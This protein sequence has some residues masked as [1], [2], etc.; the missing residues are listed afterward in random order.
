MHFLLGWS[1]QI[2]RPIIVFI[3]IA[4]VI[5]ALALA[6][7]L[8]PMNQ[9]QFTIPWAMELCA[10]L[11]W[12]AFLPSFSQPQKI[13]LGALSDQQMARH[14]PGLFALLRQKLHSLPG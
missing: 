5:F 4:M 1:H 13:P 3:S 12:L 10:G 8:V 11:T 6:L 14:T 7:D 2:P 9:S